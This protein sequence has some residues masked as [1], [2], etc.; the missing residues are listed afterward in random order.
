MH[1]G[2][3]VLTVGVNDEPHHRAAVLLARG[4]MKA[5]LRRRQRN[6]SE[7]EAPS[8]L[9]ERVISTR[10]WCMPIIYFEGVLRYYI[11]SS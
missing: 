7:K 1:R 3:S 5:V 2:E 8:L 4:A 6:I 10:H 9:S 11:L